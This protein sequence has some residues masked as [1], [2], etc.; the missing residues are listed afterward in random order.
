MD[1]VEKMARAAH[2]ATL[3]LRNEKVEAVIEIDWEMHGWRYI[4]AQRAAL[5][6]L[7]T[8]TDEMRRA[9]GEAL[10]IDTEDPHASYFD[11]A[12]N[13]HTAMIRAATEGSS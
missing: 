9:G 5:K 10:K 3:A 12:E 4:E 11:L 2:R 1:M 7:E 8:P 6:A 13:V